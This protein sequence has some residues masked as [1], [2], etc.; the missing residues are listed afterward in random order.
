MRIRNMRKFDLY[1]PYAGVAKGNVV[2]PSALSVELPTERFYDVLLQ[3]D[4]KRGL[5]EIELNDMDKAILGDGVTSLFN[6]SETAA[7]VADPFPTSGNTVELVATQN[8]ATIMQDTLIKVM[9]KQTADIK[10]EE[11]HKE[12]AK[13]ATAVKVTAEHTSDVKKEALH[14]AMAKVAAD[15]IMDELP[16]AID[17][18]VDAMVTAPHIDPQ[19]NVKEA[20]EATVGEAVKLDPG[21]CAVCKGTVGVSTDKRVKLGICRYCK[22]KVTRG[23]KLVNGELMQFTDGRTSGKIISKN[24]PSNIQPKSDRPYIPKPAKAEAAPS[25]FTTPQTA[26]DVDRHVPGM[27]VTPILQSKHGISALLT[28]NHNLAFVPIKREA[29]IAAK[30]KLTAADAMLRGGPIGSPLA[31]M[32]HLPK[33][34]AHMED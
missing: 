18:A 17:K 20:V 8:R 26:A 11:L 32:S 22:C 7:P 23:Y 6:K 1:F 34:Q 21:M 25:I 4:W 27:P 3:R 13:I 5:I 10:K 24:N 14:K 28:H 16:A 29:A 15:A 19:A 30:E 31:T 2:K 33:P 9:A 12:M